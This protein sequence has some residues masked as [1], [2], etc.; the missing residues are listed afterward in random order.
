MK[1]VRAVVRSLA[2]ALL[3]PTIGCATGVEPTQE[4]LLADAGGGSSAGSSGEGG[5]VLGGTSNSAQS[6][7]S[8]VDRGGG[9]ATGTSG[10][11]GS[12]GVG[13]GASLGGSA[14]AQAG[15][16]TSTAG[17]AGTSN[18]GAGGG[19]SGASGSAGAGG[20]PA[21]AKPSS[22]SVSATK[23]AT[24][25]QAPSA[26]GTSYDDTC[27]AGQVL[28]GFKGTVGSDH[29]YVRSAS[30]VCGTLAVAASA[31]Y[32]VTT[33]QA[34]ALPARMTAQATVQDALCPANQVVVGFAGSAGGYIDSLKFKCAPL[35]ITGQA[36][37][38]TLSFGAATD[39]GSLG[40]AAGGTAFN[41]I[42]CAAGQA[43]VSQ[44][45]SAGDAID[46]FGIACAALTL[47]LK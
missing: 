24:T 8:T 35:S 29:T 9:G 10:K 27:P 17:T 21:S 34:G 46:S 7:S 13:G 22:V 40:G 6:G 25:K 30:G 11:E 39:T 16:T 28:I 2:L 19:S 36:P 44:R 43:A 37:N 18:G 12:G 42:S 47:V 15:G 32:A 41:A 14:G 4:Q 5:G 23:N 3:A 38:H 31:P 1:R 45:V 26:G 33:S 20:M